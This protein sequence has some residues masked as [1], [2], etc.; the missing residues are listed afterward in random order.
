[1]T[2]LRVAFH[3]LG[4]KLNQLETE[5][6]AE[7]FREQGVAIL[8]FEREADLYVV[9]TCTVT[10]KAEQKARRLLRQAL[11]S[12]SHAVVLAT[13]CYAQMDRAGLEALDPRIVVIPGD[14]KEAIASLAVFLADHWQGHGE[15]AALVAEWQA[16]RLQ[17]TQGRGQDGSCADGANPSGIDRFPFRPGPLL[18]HSRPS[19]KIQDGCN[20]RCSYC[21]VCLA[22]GPSVSL[23]AS[24]VLARLQEL[25]RAGRGEAV[26]SGVNLTQYRSS[27][28]GRPLG[29]GSLILWLLEN[30]SSIALRVSSMEPDRIDEE[31]LRAFSHPRVRPHVHL[32]IQSGSDR[33]L[34]AMARRYRAETVREAG[35]ALR[36]VRD[37]PFLAADLIAGFPGEEEEDFC[38]S[39]ELCRDLGLAWVHAFPFSPR[40]GTAAWDMRPRV[41][42]RIAGERVAALLA[43]GREGQAAYLGRWRGKRVAAVVEGL[44]SG[45][46]GGTSEAGSIRRAT[47]ENYLGLLV[48]GLGPAI[49]AGQAVQVRIATEEEERR[50]PHPLPQRP[51]ESATALA[52][53]LGD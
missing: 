47:S 7:A 21:R 2:P 18:F 13:G 31:F 10:G 24:L 20:N 15:L 6:I 8:P 9:N 32:S 17:G 4:C 33:I 51:V 27:A 41:P 30:T 26:L 11:S 35:R 40:P 22:R 49:H 38:Q 53:A 45:D 48:A 23:D 36:A 29:L 39:L 46:E 28:G 25:E 12:S 52:F 50:Y 37:D 19:L 44:D 14:E 1:M 5:S 43:L 42:E 34:K 3:T 16:L